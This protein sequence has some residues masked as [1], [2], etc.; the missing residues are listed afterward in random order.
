MLL[1][2][3]Q[4]IATLLT[5]MLFYAMDFVLIHRYDKKRPA[6]GPGLLGTLVTQRIRKKICSQGSYPVTQNMRKGV[7]ESCHA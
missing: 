7:P 2:A 5:I 1:G 3:P 4:S 6:S